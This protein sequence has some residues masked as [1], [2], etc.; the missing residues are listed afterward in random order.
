MLVSPAPKLPADA[1]RTHH[2]PECRA[3]AKLRRRAKEAKGFEATRYILLVHVVEHAA[4][5]V[6]GAAVIV[7]GYIYNLHKDTCSIERMG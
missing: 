3:I 2:G 5:V 1:V 7:R 6:G 4:V